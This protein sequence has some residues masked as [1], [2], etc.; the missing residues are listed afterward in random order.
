MKIRTFV[1]IVILLITTY[2]CEERKVYTPKPLGYFRIDLPEKKYTQFDSTYPYKFI[3]PQ[4]A[5][6]KPVI[7]KDN[8][9]YWINL[10]FPKMNATVHLSYKDNKDDLLQF[11]ADARTFAYKHTV[12]AEAINEKTFDN[13]QKKVFGVYYDIRGEAASNTQFFLTDS[14]SKFVRGALYF[15][16]PPNKDSLEPVKNFI[17]EDIYKLIENF[18]WK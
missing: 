10:D 2:S 4:Y 7:A 5:K 15:N 12:K 8:E 13:K 17:Q 9:L 3:Y 1:T 14:I 11:L 6:I 16:V 18:E